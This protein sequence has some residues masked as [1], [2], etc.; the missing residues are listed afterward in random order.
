MKQFKVGGIYAGE[1]RI[2]IEVVKRTKQTITFK[3]NK[4]NW[5]EEDTEKEFRKKIRHFNNNYETI[6]LGSH[7][8]PLA[9]AWIE[10]YNSFS[11][12]SSVRS[13]SSSNTSSVKSKC[14]VT[15]YF[16]FHRLYL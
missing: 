10:M 6:N 11:T 12:S 1:D 13:S 9:G 5:W 16:I 14:A 4:P 7:V 2:E 8:A 15:L 3:Y